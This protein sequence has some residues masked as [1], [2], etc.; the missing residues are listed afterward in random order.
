MLSL[1]KLVR[2]QVGQHWALYGRGQLAPLGARQ[3]KE[4]GIVLVKPD[5]S[6]SRGLN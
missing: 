5:V 6:A 3:L 2:K 1:L 4:A